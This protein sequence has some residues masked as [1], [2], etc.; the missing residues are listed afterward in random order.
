MVSRACVISD[1]SPVLEKKFAEKKAILLTNEAG[2][3][4]ANY[5]EYSDQEI[6]SIAIQG[7]GIIDNNFSLDSYT[8][9]LLK[10]METYN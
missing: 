4:I 7:R 6:Q 2:D 3:E 5:L 10:V 1:Y 8:N 9:Q